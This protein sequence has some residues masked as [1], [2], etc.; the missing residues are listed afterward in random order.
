MKLSGRFSDTPLMKNRWGCYRREKTDLLDKQWEDRVVGPFPP[1][2][3]TF[4]SLCREIPNSWRCIFLA[5]DGLSKA[6]E[7]T[8]A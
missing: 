6:T 8:G 7:S 3:V 4:S 1:G 5:K 2:S